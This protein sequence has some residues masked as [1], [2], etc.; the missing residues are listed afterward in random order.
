M[1][2]PW[3]SAATRSA[4]GVTANYPTVGLS[5]HRVIVCPAGASRVWHHTAMPRRAA[6]A[7]GLA[8][9]R[10]IAVC[11][12]RAA[13]VGTRPGPS[14][15]RVFDAFPRERPARKLPARGR[16][17]RPQCEFVTPA[18]SRKCPRDRSE[19]QDLAA[20]VAPVTNQRWL[21]SHVRSATILGRLERPL[22]GRKAH[23]VGELSGFGRGRREP[24]GPIRL[25]HP[26]L[27]FAAGWG[28]ARC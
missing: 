13:L 15:L 18:S 26:V 6:R 28:P 2:S 9:R 11:Q 24:A 7:R 25:S 4:A 3:R 20:Q 12:T 21:K 17:P 10:V 23:L 8:P 16:L 14:W 1:S 5:L 27:F 22:V 19:N